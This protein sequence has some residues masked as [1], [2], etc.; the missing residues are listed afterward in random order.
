MVTRIAIIGGV[1]VVGL[2]AL[3]L[4]KWMRHYGDDEWPENQQWNEDQDDWL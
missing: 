1:V 3:G 2:L 4:W